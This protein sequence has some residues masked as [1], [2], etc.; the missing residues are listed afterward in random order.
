MFTG[1]IMPKRHV[2]SLAL[3]YSRLYSAILSHLQTV[4]K[5]PIYLAAGALLQINPAFA[6]TA[7][8]TNSNEQ[9]STTL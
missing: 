4:K 2:R 6:E 5:A 7:T 9:P 3:P 1:S 8:D